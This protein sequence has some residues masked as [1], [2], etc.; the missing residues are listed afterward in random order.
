MADAGLRPSE[1]AQRLGISPATLRRW[2]QQFGEFL[3]NNASTTGTGNSGRSHRRYSVED[4]VV[5]ERI[6][7]M[8]QKG[9]TYESV[10]EYFSVSGAVAPSQAAVAGEPEFDGEDETLELVQAASDQT[11]LAAPSDSAQNMPDLALLIADTLTN[12]SDSQQIILSGQQTERQLLGV[13][14]QDNFNLKEE[15]RR[16]RERMVETERRVYELRRELDKER[17][18]ERERMRQMESYLFELQRRLD[19]LSEPVSQH[20]APAAEQTYVDESYYAEEPAIEEEMQ[21][22][23]T[24]WPEE[25]SREAEQPA[26]RKRSFWDWIF[27]R[28]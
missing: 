3:S 17:Q 24:P 11:A 27:G 7:Q 2:S 5:L 26:R 8:L 1:V 25:Q 16:L 15:N 4:V 28:Y 20:E 19:S 14:L 18:E 13:V 6:Q 21:P 10:R 12:L 9:M 23:E 22:Y